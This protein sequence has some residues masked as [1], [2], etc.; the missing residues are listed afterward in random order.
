MAFKLSLIILTVL[1]WA[2]TWDAR[3]EN[4][5][6]QAVKNKLIIAHQSLQKLDA[7][8][9]EQE[10]ETEIMKS[11]MPEDEYAGGT[12][13]Q[14]AIEN[15]RENL[16]ILK[17]KRLSLARAIQHYELKYGFGPEIYQNRRIA[18]PVEYEFRR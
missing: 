8:I 5:S 12:L 18:T 7:Q 9:A 16:K 6:A 1:S 11:I 17:S 10:S 14:D 4:L 2:L 3:A 13:F 15:N